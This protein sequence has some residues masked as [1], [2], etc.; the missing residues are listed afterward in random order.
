[1]ELGGHLC[2]AIEFGCPWRA[3]RYLINMKVRMQVTIELNCLYLGSKFVVNIMTPICTF[4]I[5]TD[6]L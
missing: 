4:L 5:F 2:I 3:N 6:G 1:M